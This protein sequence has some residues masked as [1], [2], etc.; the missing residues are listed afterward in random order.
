MTDAAVKREAY[1]KILSQNV[2]L[3]YGYKDAHG[4]AHVRLP[5]PF[6]PWYSQEIP[7]EAILRLKPSFDL[8]FDFGQ[9]PEA[10]RAAFLAKDSARYPIQ[11]EAREDCRGRWG[12]PDA[13]VELDFRKLGV[14]FT[15]PFPFEEFRLAK[16]AMDE[17]HLWAS[18][19]QEVRDLQGI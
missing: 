7:K 10:E 9:K 13:H 6:R 5:V 4:V 19:P 14:W 17:I 8:A 15:L 18:L 11:F 12:Y 16:A 3:S 2:E 1:R